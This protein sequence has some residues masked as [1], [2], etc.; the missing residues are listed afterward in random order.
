MAS[1]CDLPCSLSCSATS[2]FKLPF[3][4]DVEKAGKTISRDSVHLWN[5]A[6]IKC[7]KIDTIVNNQKSS[8]GYPYYSNLINSGK[9][10]K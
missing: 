4:T 9:N 1:L 8:I 6:H 10:P 2:L 3:Q 5:D 7:T